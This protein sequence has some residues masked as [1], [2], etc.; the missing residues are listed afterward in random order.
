MMIDSDLMQSLV[1]GMI[2]LAAGLFLGRRA[3]RT[4]RS[5]Q[6]VGVDDAACGSGGCGCSGTATGSHDAD[7]T[8]TTVR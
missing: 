5:S 3:W 4:L 2:V 6:H 7:R 1:A 8:D